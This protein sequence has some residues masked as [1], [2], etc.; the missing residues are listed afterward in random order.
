MTTKA[1]IPIVSAVISLAFANFGCSFVF[2]KGPNV[3]AEQV[4][5]ESN[6]ECSSSAVPPAFDM[7][8]TAT[9]S[10][11]AIVGATQ[12]KRQFG[13]V[14][15]VLTAAIVADLALAALHGI[16]GGYGI[17]SALACRN[18]HE[19]QS[20]LQR[21]RSLRNDGEAANKAPDGAFGFTFGMTNLEAERACASSGRAWTSDEGGAACEGKSA[22]SGETSHTELQFGPDGLWSI[23]VSSPGGA[24][25]SRTYDQIQ[26]ALRTRY[27]APRRSDFKVPEA[28]ASMEQAVACAERGDM[29]V[30]T[31]WSWPNKTRLALQVRAVSGKLVIG[32]LYEQRRLKPA[33]APAPAPEPEPAAEEPASRDLESK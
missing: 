12:L 25:W 17:G 15:D 24:Q 20:E 7:V 16:S 9:H 5:A 10:V 14:E 8:F 4:T 11:S 21:A 2:S 22:T 1:T 30:V 3:S 13:V 18:A 26:H 23:D 27:G 28:C 19:R 32:M 29:N 31:A 6:I 33:P